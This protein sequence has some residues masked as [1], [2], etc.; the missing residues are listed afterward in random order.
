MTGEEVGR[1]I[2][3]LRQERGLSLRRLAVA[4]GLAPSYLCDV[5]RGRARPSLKALTALAAALGVEVSR[6]VGAPP[7]LDLREALRDPEA[8]V[9]YRGRPLSPGER[10]RV[11][12]IL[13]AA[14]AAEAPAGGPGAREAAAPP[15]GG[16]EVAAL[17]A[18]LERGHGRAPSP[19]LLSLIRETV[20]AV[21]A[22]REREGGG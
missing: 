7:S 21:L 22:E 16:A 17:A 3:H 14:L 19:E 13:D 9:S 20:R 11:V 18:H 4:A 5:E 6:L 10:G 15:A 8:A 12:Q 1:R 2:R